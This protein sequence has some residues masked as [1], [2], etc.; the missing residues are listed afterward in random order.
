MQDNIA[1]AYK[2]GL[3]E[4]RWYK[5]WEKQGYFTPKIEPEKK[6]FV[7]IMPPLNVTGEIH[8]GHALAITIEDIFVRWHR[9][10]G[11]PTLWLPG[12]DHAGIATQ[13]IIEKQLAEQGINKNELSREQ[14]QEIAWKWTNNIRENI[15]RQSKI[16]GA[17]CDW[18]R[19]CFTLDEGP[20]KA[21]R[22]SFVNLYKKGLIYRGE[23]IIN[24][25]PRCQTALS[26]LEV[27]HKNTTG[28]LFYIQYH[29]AE[30]N[31]FITI[32]TT[33]PETL[34]GD[35]AI[36]VNPEDKRYKD[37]IGKDVILPIVNRRIPVVAD[38]AVD[39]SFGSG[40][41]KITPAHDPVDFEIGKRHGLPIINIMN[42]DATINQSAINYAG[43][44]RLFC[45][46]KI[47]TD[48]KNNQQIEKIEPYMH[49]VGYCGRCG[50]M[51]EPRVSMQ[52]FV[53][54]KPLAES[55]IKVVKN[56][57]VKITPKHFT[58]V[59][60]DWMENIKDWC[61]SRQLW[62]GHRIPVWYCSKCG[63][64]TVSESEPSNCQHCGTDE[65]VQDPDVLDTWF[66]SALWP[67]ST[68]GW[69]DDTEDLRYFYP[70]SVMETG[71]D[72]LFFWVARMIMM[73][74]ENT[75]VIPFHTVYLNGL[76]RD[77][78]GEKMSKMRGNVINPVDAINVIGV[79][80]L[81]FALTSG[82]TSGNDISLGK[83]K[84]ESSRN[85][86]NKLWNASRFILQNLEKVIPDGYEQSDMEESTLS[87]AFEDRWINSRLNR[88][89]N[90]ISEL[91]V[92]FKIGEAEQQ[93]H[94]FIWSEY[95]DWYIEFVKTRLR[96]GHIEIAAL[97]N[98]AI[99]LEKLL[100]LLH[101]F[102][103]FIT[104]ELWQKLKYYLPDGNKLPASIM[105]A[106]YPIANNSLIDEEA[107][108]AVEAAI[109]VIQSIRNVRAEYKVT[110]SKFIE[111]RL[112]AGDHKDNFIALSRVIA[113]LARVKPL[114]ILSRTE[115]KTDNAKSSVLVLKEAEIV[116]PWDN[117]VDIVAEK[118]RLIKE[119]TTIQALID[120]LKRRLADKVFLSKAPS[121]IVD[122]ERA[123][124]LNLNNK[125]ER[126]LT[127]KSQL[128]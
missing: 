20:C 22:S 57:E 11:E 67:H 94:D 77:E 1:K 37:I 89:I 33:R 51:I 81:R 28:Q 46:D 124:L 9:M 118:E 78:H 43:L 16:L 104:E 113:P 82:T 88:L 65:L 86:V 59:Y 70:T 10:K 44:D 111:A 119:I 5:F 61:I 117:M 7:V 83:D 24:W 48:L 120:Q 92:D 35:T 110:P 64:P 121:Q 27:E 126:L 91:M 128:G 40:A 75:G 38:E 55:A 34:L 103:P 72:I 62:W 96:L 19:E 31:G 109:E 8:M 102:M 41:L 71:Y 2:P 12:T 50:T 122:K 3:I 6:P 95:C 25:C 116:L 93:L 47:V 52:W 73:S 68:L 90:N 108:Q 127:E 107:E 79:D 101:P 60:F 80:A 66:S 56:G 14:F 13:I 29:L 74:L 125:L 69:P 32:A 115:R 85:F 18:S 114:A 26:D 112:Y 15:S 23:R 99:I 39:P 98:S 49:S 4:D 54:T 45:R 84:L 36:A 17:S 87:M 106:P 105:I 58:K 21:V 53:R 63:E 76:I 42:D 100:R 123:K 30:G 97:T